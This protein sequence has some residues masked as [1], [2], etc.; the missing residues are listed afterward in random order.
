MPR[1]KNVII[2]MLFTIFEVNC[3]MEN[4][5]APSLIHSSHL[6]NFPEIQGP[7]FESRRRKTLFNEISLN[8]TGIEHT[9]EY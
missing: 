8:S 7:R 5:V 3:Q 2:T 1:V 6:Y 4:T 9:G